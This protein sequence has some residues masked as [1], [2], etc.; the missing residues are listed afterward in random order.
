LLIDKSIADYN[1]VRPHSSC[2]Y[3]I[4]EE[5][6]QSS[7]ALKKWWSKYIKKQEFNSCHLQT[8]NLNLKT[9]ALYSYL[10]PDMQNHAVS[11]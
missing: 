3:L 6:Y 9:N 1:C 2:D 10:G 11:I 5:A 7:S 8:K 4:P